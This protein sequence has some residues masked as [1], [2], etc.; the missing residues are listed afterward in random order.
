MARKHS[1]FSEDKMSDDTM[2]LP[3]EETKIVA[4]PDEV[5]AV[6]VA[7]K[8]ETQVKK[9]SDMAEMIAENTT[10]MPAPIK[11]SVPLRVFATVSGIKADQFKPFAMYAE[12]QK[13][14]PCPVTEWHTR[15]ESFKNRP[16]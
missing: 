9:H 13:M 7:A 5:P 3:D 4:P 2:M 14:K 12:R 16:V 15:F 1:D 10:I 11:P 8:R 6:S